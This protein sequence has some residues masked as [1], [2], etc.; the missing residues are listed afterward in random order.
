MKEFVSA[1]TDQRMVG[2]SRLKKA[3]EFKANI[4]K[5]MQ[6]GEGTI[7]FTIADKMTSGSRCLEIGDDLPKIAGGAVFGAYRHLAY[8]TIFVKETGEEIR[9]I[10]PVGK[11]LADGIIS[12]MSR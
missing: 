6:E 2:Y 4:E 12:D 1:V 8:D 7:Y 10:N 5:N 9:V 11:A 3:L